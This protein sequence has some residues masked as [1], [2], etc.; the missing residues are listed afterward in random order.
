MRGG[1]GRRRPLAGVLAFVLVMLALVAAPAARAQDD[2]LPREAAAMINN[3]RQK[4]DACGE[5]GSLGQPG[6]RQIDTAAITT[7]PMLVWNP[8]LAAVAAHHGEAMVHDHFF[9]HVDM[10][11]HTIGQRATEGGYQWRVVGENLAAGQPTLGDAMRGWLLSTAHCRNLI[12]P[13]FTEFGIARVDS[14]DPSDPYGT[15]W[16]LVFGKPEASGVKVATANGKA[17]SASR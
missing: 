12:D 17:A 4:L 5:E 10:R 7:R 14:P 13:R 1:H 8:R 2:D 11:G 6:M 3:I 9:D 15:Y 16:V